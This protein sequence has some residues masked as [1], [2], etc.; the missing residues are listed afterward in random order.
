MYDWRADLGTVPEPRERL[1][2]QTKRI[3]PLTRALG[4]AK[5]RPRAVRVLTR[6]LTEAE[7]QIDKLAELLECSWHVAFRLVTAAG[8]RELGGRLRHEH[9]HRGP[10]GLGISPLRGARRK[11]A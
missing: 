6:A 7:G 3:H 2:G 1:P 9:G 8:L 5:L 4:D 10:T 11:N